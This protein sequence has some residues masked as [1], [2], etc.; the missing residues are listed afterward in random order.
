MVGRDVI[1]S[2][3]K[4]AIRRHLLATML[5]SANTGRLNDPHRRRASFW[6]GLFKKSRMQ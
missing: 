3:E 1:E 4:E 5:R 2:G 6:Q